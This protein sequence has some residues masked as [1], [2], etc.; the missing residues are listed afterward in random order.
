M[1]R[2]ACRTLVAEEAVTNRPYKRSSILELERAALLTRKSA[3]GAQ[4]I[5]RVGQG[6]GA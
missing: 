6:A 3:D 2:P 5:P 4:W 1:V